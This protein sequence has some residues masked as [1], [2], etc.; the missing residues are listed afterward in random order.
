MKEDILESSGN[1][2]FDLGFETAEAMILQ[3]RA[4]LISD[5]R[6]YLM[7]HGMTQ[8]EAAKQFGITQARVADLVRGNWEKFSLEMLISLEARVGRRVSLSVYA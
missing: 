4:K 8:A 5:L 3:M 7:L 1:V 2:F 6:E